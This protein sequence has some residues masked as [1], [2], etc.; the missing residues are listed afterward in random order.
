MVKMF[1]NQPASQTDAIVEFF[2]RK[3][4]LGE[5][6]RDFYTNLWMLARNAFMYMSGIK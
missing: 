2:N 3:Q 1:E 6:F 5:D 4:L